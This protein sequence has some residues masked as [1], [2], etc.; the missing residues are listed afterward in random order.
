MV[1]FSCSFNR[2]YK[3]T[4]LVKVD[5]LFNKS[6]FGVDWIYPKNGRFGDLSDAI[7]TLQQPKIIAD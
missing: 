6:G 7:Y 5:G 2:F 1:Q 3:I 4:D